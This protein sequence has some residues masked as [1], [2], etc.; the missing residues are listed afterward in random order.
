MAFFG[1]PKALKK[2]RVL[3]EG[4]IGEG[5]YLRMKPT[6]VSV[7]KQTIMKIFFELKVGSRTYEVST[8]THQDSLIRKLTDG[9]PKKLLYLPQNPEQA[10]LLDNVAGKPKFA[11]DGSISYYPLFPAILYLLFPITCLLVLWAVFG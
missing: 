10:V 2:I 7:N 6:N 3:R 8:E 4:V 9:T 1:I 11:A 5:N